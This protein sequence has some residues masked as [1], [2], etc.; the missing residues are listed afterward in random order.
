MMMQKAMDWKQ[1]LMLAGAMALL[2][3]A[4]LSAEAIRASK[5]EVITVTAPRVV[6]ELRQTRIEVDVAGLIETVDR[7]I[8]NDQAKELEAIGSRRIELAVIEVPT[9]G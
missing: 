2:S 1:R 3:P 4:A 7:Q 5:L 8:A 6:P 9:R